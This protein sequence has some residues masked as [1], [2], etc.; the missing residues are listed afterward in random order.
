MTTVTL[1]LLV[2]KIISLGGR[3][4]PIASRTIKV[5]GITPSQLNIEKHLYAG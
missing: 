5:K 1:I 4:T 3:N 2:G